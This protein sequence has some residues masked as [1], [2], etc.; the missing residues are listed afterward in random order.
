MSEFYGDPIIGPHVIQQRISDLNEEKDVLATELD[1][2]QQQL[3]FAK[4]NE[5]D[6]TEAEAAAS[7]AAAALTSWKSDFEQERRELQ[8]LAETVGDELLIRDTYWVK[9]VE[10]LVCEI[11]DMPPKIPDYIV[12]DWEAT[13]DNVKA[14]YA[15]VEVGGDTYYYRSC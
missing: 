10:E 4:L 14:D 12:I 3:A 11:G 8:E 2:R 13:A 5:E 9:Y 7:T 15:S 1:S 6:T